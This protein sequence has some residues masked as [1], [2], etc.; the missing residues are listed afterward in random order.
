MKVLHI[1]NSLLPSGAETMLY[2]SA[3]Y[4]DK[5]LEKHILATGKDV[6]SFADQL[7]SVGYIIHHINENN[8]IKQ[9]LAVQKLIKQQEFDI[10][11]IHRQG[12][13]CSYAIDAKICGVHKII[14][15][16]HNVFVFHGLV[17]IREFITRQ[18]ASFIGVRHVS[19]GN[20]VHSNEWKR[21]RIRCTLIP[22]WY[23]ENRFF[24]TTSEIK[25]I[26]R[27]KLGIS[28]EM[29]CI[30][31]VGNCT[32]VKNHMSILKTIDKYKDDL[33]FRNVMY[34]HL[35]HGFQ[36]SDE[37]NYAKTNG[38]DKK[39]KFIG[40]SDPVIYLQA[41]DLYIMPS[42]YEGFGISA[43]EGLATGI[44]ALFTD[45]PGLTDFKKIDFP[46]VLYCNLDDNII[47]KEIYN[48]V[49]NGVRP[50]NIEQ[51]NLVK[52][53]FGISRGVNQY[54]EVYFSK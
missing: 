25:K 53:Y 14:R 43:I 29:F 28:D 5:S 51:A 11:H 31:S 45:V 49:T 52:K 40:F 19:I 35:G 22:N 15:T 12:E 50:N 44:P 8:Y 9:H 48:A 18:I 24:F 1:L 34:L 23:D 13:A 2:S 39:V 54:E 27:R 33:V 36:E 20:S 10:V 38:I 3:N 42:T 37:K 16:V 26:A 46:N 21:F 32:P 4:W 47:S 30:I 17:Q 6:G 41:A 7:E